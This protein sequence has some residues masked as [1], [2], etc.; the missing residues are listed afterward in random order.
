MHRHLDEP[1]VRA[2]LRDALGY[3]DVSELVDEFLLR[4][5]GNPLFV[6]EFLRFLDRQRSR[7]IPACVGASGDSSTRS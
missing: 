7:S 6:R 1:A 4:T 5:G 3:G 2:L